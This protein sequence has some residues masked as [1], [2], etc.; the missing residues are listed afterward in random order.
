MASCASN[1]PQRRRGTRVR[2]QIPV[3]IT[4]L[5][6]QVDFS[7]NCHTIL[8]NPQG[9]GV[10]CS[11]PLDAGIQLRVDDLPGW[12]TTMA[13]VACTRPMSEGSKFWIVGIAI[14]SPANLWCIAPVPED[15]G[16][17]SWPAKFSP[18]SIKL[19]EQDLFSHRF[20]TALHTEKA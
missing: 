14:E 3:R 13:R 1:Q 11:R 10:R 15:W 2:A 12:G 5:D 17:Y 4:S 19:I 9:C 7:E 8:V 16:A 18:A 20:N 6:P